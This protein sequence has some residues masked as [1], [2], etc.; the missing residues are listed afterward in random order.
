MLG[1]STT[2]NYG[3]MGNVIEQAGADNYTATYECGAMNRRAAVVDAN[4]DLSLTIR[5]WTTS[6]TPAGRVTHPGHRQ[7]ARL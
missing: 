7:R 3:A 6:A 4:G 1:Q 5:R 2:F